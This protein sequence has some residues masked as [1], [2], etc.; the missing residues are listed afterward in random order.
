MPYVLYIASALGAAALLLMMPRPGYT[1]WKLGA[2]LG[3]ATLGGLWL[4]LAR[5][6]GVSGDLGLA[7][8]A[9]AYQY[10]FSAVA[11]AAAARVITHTRPVYS[12]LWFVRVVLATAG[13][14]VVH[15]TAAADT[16]TPQDDGPLYD[17]AA[18]EPIAAVAVGFLLLAALLSVIF[19]PIEPN[20]R[21]AAPT[22]AELAQKYLADRSVNKLA[23]VVG[24]ERAAMVGATN[25]LSNVE[26]VGLDLFRSHPL[27]IELAGVILLVSLVGAVVIARM[28]VDGAA[29]G[30]GDSGNPALEDKAPIGGEGVAR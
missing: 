18:R 21:A 12:A 27:G 14:S 30:A 19:R 11:I 29:D 28:K 13:L 2:L 8:G 24:P 17:R 6:L 1:P 5:T 3:V 26:R 16:V 7:Q 4:Y 23:E 25:D 9:F 15:T 10:V 22:D 20:V